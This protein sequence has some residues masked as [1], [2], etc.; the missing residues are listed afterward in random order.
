MLSLYFKITLITEM[1]IHT[2]V[3][4]E[5]NIFVLHA[6]IAKWICIWCKK[7]LPFDNLYN[8]FMDM[9]TI[10][11]HRY[12]QEI[13]ILCIL[14]SATNIWKICEKRKSVM[15][16]ST[17]DSTIIITSG[18]SNIWSRSCQFPLPNKPVSKIPVTKVINN[19]CSTVIHITDLSCIKITESIYSI[20]I[21]IQVV[22][23]TSTP[24]ISES[25]FISLS[26][27]HLFL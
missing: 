9:Y 14:T 23:R 15:A 19:K 16:K 27:S 10:S 2:D 20:Y 18:R 22:S 4:Y 25:P 11:I 12:W 7:K 13:G 8:K 6:Y 26:L 1:Y 24:S 3:L 17:V 21:N 5:V